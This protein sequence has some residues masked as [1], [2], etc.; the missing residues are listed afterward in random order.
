MV[1]VSVY[2]FQIADCSEDLKAN[3]GPGSI[4]EQ[5]AASP[6]DVILGGGRTHF[7]PSVEEGGLSVEEL[8]TQNGFRVVTTSAELLGTDP[9][10]RLLGLFAPGTLPVQL[11]GENG[12]DRRRD[13]N[14]AGSTNSTPTSAVWTCRYPWSVNPTPTSTVYRPSSR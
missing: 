9:G 14:A 13:P 11:R 7:D 8:A 5:L 3:G 6:L 4:A 10:S 12:Q 1:D 2:G